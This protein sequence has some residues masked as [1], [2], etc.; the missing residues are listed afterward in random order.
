MGTPQSVDGTAGFSRCAQLRLRLQP[1]FCR[2]LMAQFL[3]AL[4]EKAKETRSQFGRSDP[5]PVSATA[6]SKAELPTS[7]GPAVLTESVHVSA[8]EPIT[9]AVPSTSSK[10]LGHVSTAADQ[11]KSRDD[12]PSS[13]SSHKGSQERRLP[14]KWRTYLLGLAAACLAY[15]HLGQLLQFLKHTGIGLLD[16]VA[17]AC[18]IA[19]APALPYLEMRRTYEAMRLQAFSAGVA[20]KALPQMSVEITA[21]LDEIRAMRRDLGAMAKKTAWLP[22]S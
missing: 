2:C 6:T 20:V 10:D 9:S 22:G 18:L 14:D 7:R 8:T 1:E 12:S 3:Q 21:M 5:G 11:P 15:N 16:L 17:V 13:S 4:T 19:A